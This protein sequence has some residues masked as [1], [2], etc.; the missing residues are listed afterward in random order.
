M[1]ERK[2]NKTKEKEKKNWSSNVYW[3]DGE[4]SYITTNSFNWADKRLMVLFEHTNYSA[5]QMCFYKILALLPS[6]NCLGFSWIVLLHL[7][8]YGQPIRALGSDFIL[9]ARKVSSKL[10]LHGCWIRVKRLVIVGAGGD[11]LKK[12]VSWYPLIT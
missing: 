7:R 1:K 5:F 12:N 10:H 4:W 11:G 9:S 3:R 6:T 2:Q 8:L